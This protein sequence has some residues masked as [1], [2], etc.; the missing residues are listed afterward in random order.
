M[1]KLSVL[2]IC[3]FYRSTH[4]NHVTCVIILVI[5][6]LFT[7]SLEFNDDFFFLI[8]L[9]F[10]LRVAYISRCFSQ[11]RKWICTEIYRLNYMKM[12]FCHYAISKM[13]LIAKY[14]FNVY[15]RYFQQLPFWRSDCINLQEVNLIR[16]IT[17]HRLST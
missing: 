5:F 6:F 13:F 8:F 4:R 11:R 16:I 17:P 9:S 1:P 12:G 2:C 15:Q 7:F 3:V 14:D 10:H